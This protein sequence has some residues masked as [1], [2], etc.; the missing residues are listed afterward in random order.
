MEATCFIAG[1][2]YIPIDLIITRDNAEVYKYASNKYGAI[3]KEIKLIDRGGLF[4]KPFALVSIYIPLDKREDF[5]KSVNDRVTV[6]TKAESGLSKDKNLIVLLFIAM[7]SLVSIAFMLRK[8]T[9]K[10]EPEKKPNVFKRFKIWWQKKFSKEIDIPI[11]KPD[12]TK[13]VSKGILTQKD[14]E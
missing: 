7:I 13:E 6:E 1:K 3:D 11:I 2:E 14:D 9:A 8:F 12:L 10:L 4:K 5:V